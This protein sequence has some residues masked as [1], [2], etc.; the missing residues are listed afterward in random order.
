MLL[1]NCIY[2]HSCVVYLNFGFILFFI[3]SLT[4]LFISLIFALTL[5]LDIVAQMKHSVV[6]T[7]VDMREGNVGD[8][9]LVL[10]HSVSLCLCRISQ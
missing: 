4:D 3:T 1:P 6:C 8:L 10:K 9:K 7:A 2:A 5:R